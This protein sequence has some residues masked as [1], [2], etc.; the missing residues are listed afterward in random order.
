MGGIS[1]NFGH[2]NSEHKSFRPLKR[3]L[4]DVMKVCHLLFWMGVLTKCSWFAVALGDIPWKTSV[5]VYQHGS[6]WTVVPQIWGRCW[7]A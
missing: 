5:H 2:Y 4:S 6:L 7:L 1:L 3:W